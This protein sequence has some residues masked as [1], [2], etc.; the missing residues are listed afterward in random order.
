[1]RESQNL[2]DTESAASVLGVKAGTLEVWRTYGKGPKFLKIGRS[3]R[4]RRQ[5][6]EAY[7]EDSVMSSTSEYNTKKD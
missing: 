4:Y 2:L 1:M 7:L 6:L 5:D 3:V